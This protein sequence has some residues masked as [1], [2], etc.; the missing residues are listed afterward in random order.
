MRNTDGGRGNEKFPL[1]AVDGVEIERED[2]ASAQEAHAKIVDVAGFGVE[3]RESKDSR[4]HFEARLPVDAEMALARLS[5]EKQI[6]TALVGTQPRA[7]QCNLGESAVKALLLVEVL[8]D[9]DQSFGRIRLGNG[10]MGFVRLGVKLYI[11]G[12][13]G[14]LGGGDGSFILTQGESRGGEEDEDENGSHGVA[15]AGDCVAAGTRAKSAA[16]DQL[17]AA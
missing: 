16:Q 7:I 3:V 10:M 14:R 4:T 2:S 11:D 17:S 12:T 9:K 1:V 8:N 6:G 13:A 15:P 5:V